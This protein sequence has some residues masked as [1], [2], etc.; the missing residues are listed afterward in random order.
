[1][2]N[3]IVLCTF[4]IAKIQNTDYTDADEDTQQ[5]MFCSWLVK[6]QSSTEFLKDCLTISYKS[7]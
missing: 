5:Q 4:R 1:M 7:K 2:E 6:K 3:E